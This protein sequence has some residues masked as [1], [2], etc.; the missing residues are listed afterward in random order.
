[1]HFVI[2]GPLDAPTGG[3]GYDRRLIEEL[4][5]QGWRAA[6]L[7]LAGGWPFPDAAMRGEAAAALAGLP[8]AAVVLGDGLAFGAMPEALEREAGRLGLVALVHHPLGDESGLGP[9]ER[10]RLLQIIASEIAVISSQLGADSAAA[11]PP[12]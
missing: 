10:A 7:P 8:E 6:H 4:P 3:Y 5:A 1:V 11:A 12:G 2:P 9:A